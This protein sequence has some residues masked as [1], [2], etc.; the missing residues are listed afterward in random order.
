MRAGWR[1]GGKIT[2][3]NWRSDHVRGRWGPWRGL[4]GRTFWAILGTPHAR[5]ARA[6]GA[7]ASP[8][9]DVVCGKCL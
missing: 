7:K 9:K 5:G 1:Q 2:R 4:R 6:D 3:S 8:S